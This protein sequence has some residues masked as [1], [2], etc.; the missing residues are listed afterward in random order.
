MLTKGHFRAALALAAIA[1]T[2]LAGTAAASARSLVV[3]RLTLDAYGRE[4]PR[5]ESG[6]TRRG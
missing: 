3:K 6:C 5:T 1:I 4:R 2:A